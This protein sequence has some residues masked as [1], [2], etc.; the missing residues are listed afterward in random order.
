MWSIGIITYL[1]LCGKLPFDHEFS[2][3]EVARKIIEENPDLNNDLNSASGEA[4]SF[5]RGMS[6][7]LNLELLNKQPT[8]RLKIT[9]ALRHAWMGHFGLVDNFQ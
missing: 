1:L 2:G 7:L 9:K 5:V 6:F 8:K 4:L 3:N